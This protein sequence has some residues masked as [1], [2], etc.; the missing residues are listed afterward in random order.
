MDRTTSASSMH[1]N[2][3]T[4]T[5]R[6]EAQSAGLTAN[7]NIRNDE[8]LMLLASRR[9]LLARSDWLA[10]EPTRPL[11]LNFPAN[12]N[13][14]RV[15]RRKKIKKTP[16]KASKPAQPRL[17]TPLFEKRLQTNDYVM[18]GALPPP[19]DSKIKIKVGTDAFDSQTCPSRRSHTSR[20]AS[21]CSQSTA[22]SRLSEE[23]MLL[24]EDGDTFDANLVEVQPFHVHSGE[25]VELVESSGFENL[26]PLYGAGRSTQATRGHSPAYSNQ[27]M[28]QQ[29]AVSPL[30]KRITMIAE[31]NQRIDLPDDEVLAGAPCDEQRFRGP[32]PAG[33]IDSFDSTREP[34]HT[35][36]VKSADD[37]DPDSNAEDAWRLLMGIAT[38]VASSA[39]IKALNSMS[40]HVTTS[41]SPRPASPDLV[42][43]FDTSVLSPRSKRSEHSEYGSEP[44]D[45]PLVGSHHPAAPPVVPAQIPAQPSHTIPEE[46]HGESLWRDFIIG[47]QDSESEDELHSAWQRKRKRRRSSTSD[48]SQSF[49]LSGLGTSDK[50][51]QGGTVALS[52]PSFVPITE[53]NESD[54]LHD[55]SESIDDIPLDFAAGSK[56]TQNIHALSPMRWL[57]KKSK[58]RGADGQR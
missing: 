49:L 46:D 14:D 43:G 18:S 39:S 42:G 30:D 45:T 54:R 27:T 16:N 48:Q 40:E 57:S 4:Q 51:T 33:E 6:N 15:G 25:P 22:L 50:A 23:S 10:L 13:N 47:S 5:Q 55:Q 41:E 9:K 36:T 58:R 1:D 21:L 26:M 29:P 35:D 53:L 44:S 38:Q 12:S 28:L 17:L 56:G 11:H 34:I 31:H 37:N 2:R 7:A 24:G 52:P 3:T 20:N 8:E 19:S 32:K